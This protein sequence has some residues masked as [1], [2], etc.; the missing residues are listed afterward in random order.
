[1]SAQL[2]AKY[3]DHIIFAGRHYDKLQYAFQQLQTIGA[4]AESVM[5]D[6]A[7]ETQ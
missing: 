2:L 7:D 1:M 3:G 6:T 5:L 4:K